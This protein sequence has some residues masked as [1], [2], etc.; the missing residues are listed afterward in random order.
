MIAIDQSGPRRRPRV[1]LVGL[2]PVAL[3]IGVAACG[4]LGFDDVALGGDGATGAAELSY[5]DD[6]VYA[7]LDQTAVSLTPV[8]NGRSAVH[9]RAWIFPRGSRSIRGPG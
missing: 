7:V 3:A 9:D 6:T 4:R 2:L 8:F 1:A 5:P